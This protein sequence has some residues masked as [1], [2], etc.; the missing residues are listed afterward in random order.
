MGLYFGTNF[1]NNITASDNDDIVYGYGGNDILNG[2]LGNDQLIGGTGNDLLIG[3]EGA[4]FLSGG[5]GSD[6]ADYRG[7][8]ADVFV[9]LKHRFGD[10]RGFGGTA[11]GDHLVGI[12]N[13]IGGDGSDDLRGDDNANV[14]TGGEG[15][16]YLRGYDGNDQL[17][18][19]ED[20]DW[21][22]G[23]AGADHIDGGQDTDR[24]FYSESNAAV[25]I[26]LGLFQASGGHAEG[27]TLQAVEEVSGSLYN[28]QLTGDA[29]ENSF[30]GND[31]ND[32][33]R[34]L[35]GDDGLWGGDGNDT[36]EGGLDEDYLHGGE[37]NDTASYEHAAKAIAIAL[38]GLHIRFGESIGDQLFSIERLMGSEFNDVLG[39]S[40]GNNRLTGRGG[41]DVLYAEAGN[42]DLFGD[43]GADFLWGG[44]GSDDLTGGGGA[45]TFFFLD[46]TELGDTI[47]DFG[48]GNDVLQFDGDAF[49]GL[50]DGPL[51]P[52]LFLANQSGNANN[53][54]QRFIYETDTGI[55]RYDA[56][57]SQGG[58]VSIVATLTGAPVITAADIVIG[59]LPLFA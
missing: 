50:A 45:D 54:S 8:I 9:S 14:L 11:E 1:A 31:G 27:D 41:A 35:A 24:A 53:A 32:Q 13:V 2:G 30:S 15:E 26:D 6:T 47:E 33:L 57:G 4:D 12:E 55:L 48:T 21:I 58:G 49:G 5:S 20:S 3:G 38:E 51:D 37:G 39:G 18:G 36:L 16:D 19:G 23:G 7:N 17:F 44:E 52:S 42:D 40:S 46:L 43:Q 29:Q 34:G 10:G 59:E 56:N 28:D 25:I 22:F